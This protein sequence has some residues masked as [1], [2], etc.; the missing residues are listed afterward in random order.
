MYVRVFETTRLDS[1]IQEPVVETVSD[2]VL[3]KLYSVFSESIVLGALDLIDQEKGRFFLT[4]LKIYA[5]PPI[6]NKTHNAVVLSTIR[7]FGFN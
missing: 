2:D 7:S 1:N 6:S 3:H 4:V 5:H